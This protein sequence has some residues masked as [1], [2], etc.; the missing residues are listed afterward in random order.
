MEEPM[1]DIRH[2]HPGAIWPESI[3]AHWSLYLIEGIVLIL[4]GVAAVL[5]PVIASLAVAIFLGWLFLMG[6]IVGAITTLAHRRAP[7]FWWSLVSALATIAAGLVL[8][9]WPIGGA[10]SITV[11]LAA[12]LVAEGVASIMFAI[13]HRGHMHNGAT[14]MVFNGVLDVVLAA[15]IAWLLPVGALWAL[16]LFIGIDFLFGGAALVAMALEARHAA[17]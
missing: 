11:V 1:V 7:G 17:A 13:R 5:V 8:V 2:T 14:W 6:G 10:V 4:L 9:A 3:K 12:Y 16:G 15:V